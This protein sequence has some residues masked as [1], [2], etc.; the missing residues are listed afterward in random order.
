MTRV[1]VSTVIPHSAD[2][3]WGAVKDFNEYRWGEGVGVS[4]IENESDA[5]TPGAIRNF[6]YYGQLSRQRLVVHSPEERTQSWESVAAFDPTLRYYRATLRITPVTT[7]N[8]SFVEWWSD[9]EST[10]EATNEWL[11]LQQREFGKSLDR[12]KRLLDE[13]RSPCDA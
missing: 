5:N 8:G 12:L 6:K 1:Y 11:T 10:P 13:G 2:A 7:T 3:V 4:H 9:F